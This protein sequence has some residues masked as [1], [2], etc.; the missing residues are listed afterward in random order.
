MSD[1]LG[2]QGKDLAWEYVDLFEHAP[3]GYV[4][5][6]SSGR[7]ER[8]NATLASWIGTPAED[9]IGKRFQDL[10]NIA[11]KIYYE[12]HFAPLLRMQGHFDEVALDLVTSSGATMPMLVNARESRDSAGNL[13][14]LRIS[15]ECRDFRV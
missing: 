2:S 1:D 13:L 12:T 5:A 14:S 3:C 10:L 9:L 11:G 6:G 8:V 15:R 7:I 4:I